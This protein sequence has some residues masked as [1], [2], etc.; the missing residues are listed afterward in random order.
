MFYLRVSLM[1]N[2]VNTTEA[3]GVILINFRL[4][5]NSVLN[6][7]VVMIKTISI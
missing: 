7:Q 3:I 6:V 4:S 5:A 1:I 2:D